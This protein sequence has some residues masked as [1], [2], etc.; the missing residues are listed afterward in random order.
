MDGRVDLHIHSTASDGTLSP[1]QILAL[2]ERLNLKAIAITDHDAVEG[3]IEALESGIPETLDFLTG[4]E[5]SASPPPSFE[6]SGTL[7]ILGYGFDVRD[8]GLNMLLQNL[9]AARRNR[10]PQ[11][12]E[13][14]NAEGISISLDDVAKACG[15]CQLG[16]PHIARYLV[17]RG[18]A[19][20]ID[21]AFDTFLGRGRP[22]YVEKFRISCETALQA[23]H[24]A[25]GLSVLAHPFILKNVTRQRLESLI[26]TL[27]QQGL[28]GIEV[29]YPEHS[30]RQ[31]SLYTELAQ[32]HALI[33]TGGTDY[34]GANRPDIQ[35]GFGKGN[36]FVPFHLYESILKH[37]SRGWPSP[38]A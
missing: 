15:K 4:V 5:I 21:D 8:P 25:G 7:H 37:L 32:R 38:H 13:R 20:S 18:F 11:I 12:I 34:H 31:V 29:F 24:Q 19:D 35:M 28:E 2:A 14:L 6:D 10:N 36:F 9:Q 1:S 22:A 27:K 23:I 33:M 3:N 17:Q 16:R 26:V 30:P